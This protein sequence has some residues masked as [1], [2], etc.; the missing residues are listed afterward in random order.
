MDKDN[1]R[2][3]ERLVSIR[4][5]A[6]RLGVS[7]KTIHRHLTR[8][9]LTKVKIG[10]RTFIDS[11]ELITYTGEPG[12]HSLK[13][14]DRHIRDTETGCADTV[15]VSRQR[16]ENLLIELGELRKQ[17][18]ILLAERVRHEATVAS[19]TEREKE[20]DL[21]LARARS[22]E[23]RKSDRERELAAARERIKQLEGELARLQSQKQWWQK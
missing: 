9:H 12:V 4:T 10:T 11:S 23:S 13:D 15:T 3:H 21:A 20:L 14:K 8:G 16:Y 1:A 17:N 18:E 6:E 19:L 22:G 5:A 2:F 7:T